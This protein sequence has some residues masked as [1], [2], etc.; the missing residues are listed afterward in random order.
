MG[1][2]SLLDLLMHG[3]FTIFI[4]LL[5]SIFSLKVVVEKLIQ[6]SCLKE[7]H[8]EDLTNKIME[9]IERKSLKEALQTSKTYKIDVLFF[10]VSSPLAAV[11]K[12]IFEHFYLS[13]E[14][15]Q[16]SA[17]NKLDQETAKLEKGLGVLAT[18]GSISP[19]IGLFG[20]VIGIIKSFSALSLSDT[21]NYTHVMSGIAE[22]LIATAAG[23]LVAVPAVLFYN[24][25]MKKIKLNLPSLDEYIANLIRTI[26]K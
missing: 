6:F 18:L 9:C 17:F 13:K 12:H 22:A 11:Y 15:L 20:T 10:K 8:N 5:C 19:F 23:L 26:K 3:G 21:S 25:F 2:E 16:E 1:S 24:Y 4:L 14:E 7:K